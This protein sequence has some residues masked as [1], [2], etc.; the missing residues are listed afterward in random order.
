M[1]NKQGNNYSHYFAVKTEIQ[2]LQYV[3]EVGIEHIKTYCSFFDKS[4]GI[5]FFQPPNFTSIL[6]QWRSMRY[7]TISH[8]NFK[9]QAVSVKVSA[10]KGKCSILDIL[11]FVQCY[12]HVLQ[13]IVQNFQLLGC[14][15]VSQQERYTKP[16]NFPILAM[17]KIVGKFCSQVRFPSLWCCSPSLYAFGT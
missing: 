9:V 11:L 16:G 13:S 5:F 12:C 1:F 17:I 8:Q 14:W 10:V 3:Y 4:K 7:S 6:Y 15:K 2:N